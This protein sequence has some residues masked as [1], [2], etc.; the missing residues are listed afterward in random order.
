MEK[1]GVNKQTKHTSN[2]HKHFHPV[3]ILRPFLAC[4]PGLYL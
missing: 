1:N 4:S 2:E 3:G